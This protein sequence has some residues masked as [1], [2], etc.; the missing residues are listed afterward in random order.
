MH[1]IEEP[2]SKRSRAA[3]PAPGRLLRRTLAAVRR[4][5]TRAS[6]GADREALLDGAITDL[7]TLNRSTEQDFLVVGEKLMEFLAAARRIAADISALSEL[8]SATNGARAS[9]VLG[10]V[11]E[12]SRE[13]QA[14]AEAGDRTLQVVCD[15]TRQIG[16]TFGGFG[17][18]VAVFRVL[19]S[20][21]RIETARLGDAGS[22]FGSLAEEV[23]AVTGSIE[24]SGQGILEASSILHRNMQTALARVAG[25]RA[26]ELKE[27]PALAAEVM[28]SFGSLEERYRRASE[29]SR[30]QAAEYEEVSAV[31]GD[32]ITAIQFHDITRQ[33]V[34]HVAEALK[35][36]RAE[37]GQGSADPL[38]TVA[39]LTLQSSQ[40]SNAERLF[41]TSAGRIERDLDGI[42]QRVR[43][44]AE[45]SKTLMGSSAD[46]G[47]SCL[48]QL[49]GHF[50]DIL[51]VAGTCAGAEADTRATLAELEDAVGRMRESVE[52]VRRIEIRIRRMAINATVRAVHIGDAGN[53]LNVLAEVMQ[54]LALDSNDITNKVA[55]GLD[56]IAEAATCLSGGSDWQAASEDAA[57]DTVLTEMR[58]AILELHSS[59]ESSFSRL[60]QI[61]ALSARLGE[62]IQSARAGFSVG[63]VFTEA[64][65]R[66]R[67]ALEQ[68]GG[69]AGLAR[70]GDVE[71]AG[72]R[73]LED[74]AQH[75][76][77]HAERVV[78]ESVTTGE[79]TGPAAPADASR[80]VSGA[81]DLG[82]NVELF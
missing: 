49:E 44:M 45:A 13:T 20:L 57:S 19:G 52:E 11:L 60:H 58:G 5:C 65:D 16:R 78:H 31:I 1:Q 32:V 47:S 46:E 27:L 82:E 40:L 77:M 73:R 76:T 53:A 36:L 80:A 75:Y 72:E 4:L 24:T 67:G 62:E 26:S 79:A 14:R 42:A 12:R 37:F 38:D 64:I 22:E 8:N 6:T 21:T 81:E 18:T 41:A 68:I 71:S 56:A 33:Q 28:S 66:A 50:T 34:E 15:A 23:N 59:S 63:A 69:Q 55:A 10:G 30:R 39:V 54:R 35:R 29:A 51:K 2:D 43:N 61:T 3:R 17:D 70:R 7:E 25:L 48:L 74:S 9:R